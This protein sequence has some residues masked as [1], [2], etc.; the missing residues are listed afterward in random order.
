MNPKVHWT[1]QILWQFGGDVRFCLIA[2]FWDRFLVADRG[3]K[4]MMATK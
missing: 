4:V 1:H 2:V 3:A